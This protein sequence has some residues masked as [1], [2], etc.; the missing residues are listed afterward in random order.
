[1]KKRIMA[2]VQAAVLILSAEAG[3][4]S[5]LGRAADSDVKDGPQLTECELRITPDAGPVYPTSPSRSVKSAKKA[6]T[7]GDNPQI[8][9]QGM[10]PEDVCATAVTVDPDVYIQPTKDAILYAYDISLY[11]QD[12]VYEPDGET[13]L[14]SVTG[15]AIRNAIEAGTALT[16]VHIPDNP[17]EPVSYI[18]DLTAENDTLTFMT[19][20]FSVYLIKEGE[21]GVIQTDRNVYHYL[22]GEKNASGEITNTPYEFPAVN[23]SGIVTN[24]SSQIVRDGNTLNEP[25]VPGQQNGKSFLGWY[26]VGV[27]HGGDAAAGATFS[28]P[29]SA[30]VNDD[31]VDFSEPVSVTEDN[32]HYYLA[33]LY[34]EYRIVRF[35]EYLPTGNMVYS[36]KMVVLGTTADNSLGGRVR[37]DDVKAPDHGSENFFYG[38]K[39]ETGSPNGSLQREFTTRDEQG[40]F[41][42]SYFDFTDSDFPLNPYWADSIYIDLIPMHQN[43]HWLNYNTKDSDATYFAP[44]FVTQTGS[45][46]K[47]TSAL[48]RQH[49]PV[50][51]GYTFMGW[52]LDENCT[53]AQ[54]LSDASGNLVSPHT[55]GYQMSGDM[56]IYAKWT[57]DGG[58]A[59]YKYIY[60]QQLPTDSVYDIDDPSKKHYGFVR[61]VTATGEA[62]PGHLTPVPAVFT[63]DDKQEPY[64]I[65]QD[66]YTVR[67]DPQQEILPDGTTLVNIYYDRKKWDIEFKLYNRDYTYTAT[68]GDTGT[69]YGWIDDQYKQLTREQIGENYS[70]SAYSFTSYSAPYWSGWRDTYV[71]N[72]DG[73]YEYHQLYS[74]RYNW[75]TDSS[76]QNRYTGEVY[77][78]NG[79]VLY[80]GTRYQKNGSNFVPTTAEDEGL[81]GVDSNGHYVELIRNNQPVY[82]WYYNGEEFT[83]TRYT[84]SNNTS[85]GWHRYKLLSGLYG[86]TFKQAAEAEHKD[87]SWPTAYDWRVSYTGSSAS[88]RRITFLDGFTEPNNVIYYGETATTGTRYIRH[89]KQ[90]INA[91]GWTLANETPISGTGTFSFELS[92]KYQGFELLEYRVKTINGNWGGWQTAIDKAEV[93]QCYELEIRYKREQYDLIFLDEN[94][95][96]SNP[97]SV[98]THWFEEDLTDHGKDGANEEP[99]P[100]NTADVTYV[101]W[102]PDLRGLTM[103]ASNLVVYPERERPVYQVIIDPDGGEFKTDSYSTFFKLRYPNYKI[104]EYELTRNYR[105][106]REGEWGDFVFIYV[107]PDEN[108]EPPIDPDTGEEMKRYAKYVRRDDPL[109]AKYADWLAKDDHGNIQYY[110]QATDM[111]GRDSL[112]CWYEVDF[113][114]G[115]PF[116]DDNGNPIERPYNFAADAKHNTRLRA[117]WMNTGK[118]FAVQY[119]GLYDDDAN[120]IQVSG[121]VENG[122][123]LTGIADQSVVTVAAMPTNIVTIPDDPTKEYVFEYWDINGLHVMPGDQLRITEAI[124]D[125]SLV[126]K[127][128][129]VYAL[130][131]QSSHNQQLIHLKLHAN[132]VAEGASVEQTYM[133]DELQN[134]Q[135]NHRVDLADYQTTFTREHFRLVGWST[136]PNADDP[137]AVVFALN[138]QVGA[139]L[140]QPGI[141]GD[142][143]SFTSHL[144]AVWE[145]IPPAPTGVHDSKAPYLLM[146]VIAAMLVAAVIYRRKEGM[147][148][149]SPPL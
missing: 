132:Y 2:A 46:Q 117:K 81:Y 26:V 65:T 147:H 128:Q 92:N 122:A 91:T 107:E 89:Y 123:N 19:D 94:D 64:K 106:V 73:A 140:D 80:T 36:Q 63:D 148:D 43:G 62:G 115:E 22:T 130:K 54:Q 47:I 101:R 105:P 44:S 17:S 40:T 14:V 52:Y 11:S 112:V 145:Q 102:S 25:P 90:D 37:L 48:L 69:Q 45:G 82:K 109:A 149:D 35:H 98:Y 55:N 50:W 15:R 74:Y 49:I 6:P 39:I 70:F 124:A 59:Q 57:Y 76:H 83:D 113:E 3:Q 9:L 51:P 127:L 104:E 56:T 139:Y 134:M 79:T 93:T 8:M 18:Q 131:E 60:W 33:P 146:V 100:E 137:D 7:R 88:G 53:D 77:Q 32:V 133:G 28:W 68:T 129:A 5:L 118:Q 27:S 31:R 103:P 41:I 21:D 29:D 78:Q 86:Q 108:F 61:A 34:R 71:I 99:L 75:Y 13:I 125:S 143:E 97:Q 116:L 20:S 135:Q 142:A 23:E 42:E 126:V 121:A 24:V 4:F 16:V 72:S 141:P 120:G 10:L 87:V 136:K 144:Y 1:M 12:A 96:P 114:T 66:Y 84:R 95:D 85:N 119:E 138:A 67:T 30:A 111:D 58:I 110:R 38:W